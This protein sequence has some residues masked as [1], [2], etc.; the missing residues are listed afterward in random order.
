MLRG[1]WT[2]VFLSLQLLQRWSGR[3]TT[4]I[5]VLRP[6]WSTL[7]PCWIWK[8]EGHPFSLSCPAQALARGYAYPARRAPTKC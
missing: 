7:F 6:R 2:V 4:S 5:H 1:T 3:I 8:V